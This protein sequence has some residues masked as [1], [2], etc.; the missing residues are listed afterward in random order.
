MLHIG[1]DPAMNE[2]QQMRLFVVNAFLGI[3]FALTILF[4]II[5]VSLGSY[6]ALQGLGVL[7]VMTII[8]L[9]NHKGYHTA[10]RVMITYGLMLTALAL[11]LADRRT[12]TEFILIAL[13]CCSV[14]VYSEVTSIL[15]SFFFAFACYV[16]YVWVDSTLPFT[17]DPSVP[18]VLTQNSLMFLSAFAVMA[19]SLAFRSLINRYSQ[20]LRVAHGEVRSVNEELKATNEELFALSEKLNYLVQHKTAELQAYLDTININLLSATSDLQGNIISVNKPLLEA[21]GY[22]EKELIGRG[23]RIIEA[24]VYSD[25][26]HNGMYETIR[27]GNSW[28]GEVKYMAKDGSYFWVDKVVMPVQLHDK[29]IAYFLCL[30]LPI[31][32][33]K[34][35][36]ELQR[37]NAEVFEAIADATSHRV[38]GP[39]ARIIGLI[40]L[41]ERNGIKPDETPWVS[42]QLKENI[43]ELDKA[44][45]ALTETVNKHSRKRS[46]K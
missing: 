46:N 17:P 8:F 3:S 35:A 6:S 15:S 42:A 36:E 12:G 24:D 29:S 19:Q 41:T 45:S 16:V 11:A 1:Y 40:N 44:T 27:A 37:R 28:R 30:A 7:P 38:R 23:H 25:P 31:N 20:R 18:Y 43:V 26:M 2:N 4:L 22:D 33:R 9:L 5:F 14:I 34:M 13:G 39:M 10:A 32:E 21:T